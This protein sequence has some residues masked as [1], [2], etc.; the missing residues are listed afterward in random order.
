[1]GLSCVSI[2]ALLMIWQ[3]TYRLKKF[4]IYRKLSEISENGGDLRP[5]ANNKVNFVDITNNGLIIKVNPNE[6]VYDLWHF[7]EKKA[8]NTFI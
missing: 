4:R 5:I 8:K 6:A 7:V 1:M 2:T 3:S